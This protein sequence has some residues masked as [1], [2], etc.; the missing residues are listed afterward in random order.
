VFKNS[1]VSP[2]SQK[3]TSGHESYLSAR[4]NISTLM[5]INVVKNPLSTI[6]RKEF[7]CKVG[8]NKTKSYMSSMNTVTHLVRIG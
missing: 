3:P 1:F 5:L 6:K 4:V 8:R 2:R 7:S